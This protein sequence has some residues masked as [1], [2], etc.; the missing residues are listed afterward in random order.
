[1]AEFMGDNFVEIGGIAERVTI[2]PPVSKD[3]ICFIVT[4]LFTW[5]KFLVLPLRRQGLG[6]KRRN[7]GSHSKEKGPGIAKNIGQGVNLPGRKKLQGQVLVREHITGVY[8]AA[9][10]L[11]VCRRL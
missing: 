8:H 5:C 11:L 6:E 4:G 10:W 3:E 9:L 7:P 2:V 1:M